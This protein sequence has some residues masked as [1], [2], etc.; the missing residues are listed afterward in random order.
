MQMQFLIGGQQVTLD[1]GPVVR[2]LGEQLM[3]VPVVRQYLQA[4]RAAMGTLL[5]FGAAWFL[6]DVPFEAGGL[7]E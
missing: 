2:I 5:C 7:K 3:A 4:T 6:K 1:L